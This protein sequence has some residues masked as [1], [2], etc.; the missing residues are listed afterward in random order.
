MIDQQ[1]GSGCPSGGNI[2]RLHERMNPNTVKD[3]AH[4]EID[5]IPPLHA[6]F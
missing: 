5:K 4:K 3:A 2:C 1:S 6:E